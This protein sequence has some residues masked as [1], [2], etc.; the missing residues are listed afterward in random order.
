[1]YKSAATEFQPT[2]KQGKAWGGSRAFKRARKARNMLH[3]IRKQNPE[4]TAQQAFKQLRA[5]ADKSL[6]DGWTKEDMNLFIDRYITNDPHQNNYYNH[7]TLFSK[8]KGQIFNKRSALDEDR[9][10]D[11]PLGQ[12]RSTVRSGL[13][14]LGSGVVGGFTFMPELAWSG[15]KTLA[16]GLSGKGW[17]WQSTDWNPLDNLNV[18]SSIADYK[19]TGK[20][21]QRGVNSLSTN[22][23]YMA[24]PYMFGGI[25]S[26]AS[27]LGR[28]TRSVN[29]SKN[30]AYRLA[31]KQGKGSIPAVQSAMGAAGRTMYN[32]VKTVGKN[33]HKL[34][35]NPLGSVKETGA[36]IRRNFKKSPWGTTFDVGA[37]TVLGPGMSLF[38][39]VGG[40]AQ[41]LND[42]YSGGAV[43]R[44][45]GALNANGEP[46]N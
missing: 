2:A 35:A 24:Q 43:P 42:Y 37:N 26:S 12:L 29:R 7:G 5:G 30:L 36:T 46:V 44:L 31:R 1:M 34:V 19:T 41:P 33:M 23:G 9:L 20:A 22:L 10:I 14:S 28:G 4:L 18:D 27:V 6:F 25:G 11:K 45:S 32:N 38:E 3:L 16:G 40:P 39:M 8:N 17:Q 15:V 13:T 21:L